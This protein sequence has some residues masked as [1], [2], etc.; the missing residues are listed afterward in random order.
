MNENEERS[1]IISLRKV[2]K[3]YNP[4]HPNCV[5]VLK[6]VDLDVVPGEMLAVVGASGVGKSTLLHLMGTLDRPTSGTI[7]FG[8]LD[9][10]GMD[11][12]ELARFRNRTIGFVFQ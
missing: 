10:S 12:I 7:R 5:E 2:V 4:Q 1:P 8:T 9:V 11:N 6:G 3:I